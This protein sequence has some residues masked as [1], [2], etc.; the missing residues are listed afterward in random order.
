MLCAAKVSLDWRSTYWGSTATPGAAD[1]SSGVFDERADRNGA[2][3]P[4]SREVVADPVH[5][6][7]SRREK[8][9]VDELHGIGESDWVI[10]NWT[11][12]GVPVDNS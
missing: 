9:E 1:T 11:N 4:E 5:W 2:P 10:V 3:Q 8:A 7:M 6:K 12:A